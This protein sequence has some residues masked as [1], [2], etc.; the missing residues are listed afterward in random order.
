MFIFIQLR[1]YIDDFF[2]E[3]KTDLELQIFMRDMRA[4]LI[5]LSSVQF[6]LEPSLDAEHIYHLNEGISKIDYVL[7]INNYLNEKLKVYKLS[8]LR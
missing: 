4:K 7:E 2:S 8:Q 6:N 1:R 5:K 3:V